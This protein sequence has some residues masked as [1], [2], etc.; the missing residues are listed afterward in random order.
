M[1]IANL[2]GWKFYSLMNKDEGSKVYEC[3]CLVL[4]EDH[5]RVP[6]DEKLSRIDGKGFGRG[7][8]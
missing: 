3:V 4:N 6:C 7:D 1:H 5:A 8:S 2:N